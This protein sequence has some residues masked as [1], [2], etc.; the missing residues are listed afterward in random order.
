V[1]QVQPVIQPARS[2]RSQVDLASGVGRRLHDALGSLS[3]ND[4][5]IA[6]LILRDPFVAAFSTVEQVAATAGVSKAAVARFGMR[7]G[8]AGYA[9]LR[10]DLRNHWQERTTEKPM[11]DLSVP[12]GSEQRESALAVRSALTTR[13]AYTVGALSRLAETIDPATLTRCAELLARPGARIHVMGERR[14]Y[15]VAAHLLRSLR[16]LGCDAR[17]FHT[18]ELGLRLA[19]DQVAARHVL[20]VCAFRR[21]AHTTGVVLRHA[22]ERGATSI[23]LTD[24][25]D[26]PFVSSADELLVCASTGNLL[27]D[28][29][30]PAVFCVE[31]LCDLMIQRIGERVE[32]HVRRVHEQTQLADFDDTEQTAELL[33]PHRPRRRRLSGA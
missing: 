23:L 22:R 5:A 6:E 26:C 20:V 30:V 8:Y 31:A 29:S 14:G 16:W 33:R 12:D 18:E 15:A 32:R 10:Q 21:Y 17:M 19:L 28:S 11:H 7:L 4:R 13:L 3:A 1:N 9:E 2:A 25:L 27:I 24:S